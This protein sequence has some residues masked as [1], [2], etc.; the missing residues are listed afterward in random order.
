MNPEVT[1]SL[2]YAHNFPLTCNVG[3]LMTRKYRLDAVDNS[4]SPS[5]LEVLHLCPSVTPLKYHKN[6][7]VRILLDPG[8][9]TRLQQLIGLLLQHSSFMFGQDKS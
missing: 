8:A 7:R 5:P 9:V 2:A 6:T 1:R 3:N 4:S